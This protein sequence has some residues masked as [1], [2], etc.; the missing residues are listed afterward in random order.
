MVPILPVFSLLFSGAIIRLPKPIQ[1]IVLMVSFL[2]GLFFF[3]LVYTQ[4]DIRQQFSLWAKENL[5][6]N[7][8]ILS[9]SGN[10]VNLPI[11]TNHH[12]INFDFYQLEEEGQLEFLCQNLEKADYVLV[13]SRRVFANHKKNQF[14]ITANYYQKLFSDQLGF[15]LLETFSPTGRYH[16][17]N[18][19][20]QTSE[21]SAEETWTVFDHPT[22]RLYQKTKP[23]LAQDY[24]NI[25]SR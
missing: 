2:P 18:L 21:I 14:P 15:S 1:Y 23:Y 13:P 12:I 8:I 9:E 6:Q 24:Q 22:I 25:L 20:Y 11:N 3:D 4:P 5:S 19:Y 16:L 7:S 17:T 10:V